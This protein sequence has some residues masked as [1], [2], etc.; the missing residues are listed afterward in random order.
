MDTFVYIENI[1]TYEKLI[2]VEHDILK[3]LYN[4]MVEQEQLLTNIEPFSN[5]KTD[6]CFTKMMYILISIMIV[7]NYKKV[8]RFFKKLL[9]I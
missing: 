5:Y 8:I 7:I 3:K 9:K 4:L 6:C 2:N 1:D